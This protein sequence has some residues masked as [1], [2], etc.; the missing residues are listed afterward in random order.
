MRHQKPQKQEEEEE[1]DEDYDD[2]QSNHSV[3]DISQNKNHSSIGSIQ[4]D[5]QEPTS[6]LSPVPIQNNPL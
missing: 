5:N 4:M 2:E 3:M 1:E 6:Q